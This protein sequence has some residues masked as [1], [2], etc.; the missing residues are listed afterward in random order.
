[1]EVLIR[2]LWFFQLFIYL[3]IFTTFCIW[4][5]IVQPHLLLRNIQV[6]TFFDYIPLFLDGHAT[7]WN[8]EQILE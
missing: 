5:F 4:T 7:C 1:M 2:F 6:H 3:F 8:W